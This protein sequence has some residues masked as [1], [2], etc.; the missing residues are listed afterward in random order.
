MTQTRARRR[1]T[2]PPVAEL[3]VPTFIRAHGSGGPTRAAV[4]RTGLLAPAAAFA[5]HPT[6]GEDASD[7]W[8]PAADARVG[9]YHSLPEEDALEKASVV[10]TQLLEDPTDVA[11]W[12]HLGMSKL[13]FNF[14][15]AAAASADGALTVLARGLEVNSSSPSLWAAYLRIFSRRFTLAEARDMMEHALKYVPASPAMWRIIVG[16]HDEPQSAAAFARRAIVALSTAAK[17]APPGPGAA[18][19]RA[20]A[21]AGGAAGARQRYQCAT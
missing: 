21:V 20:A 18:A 5:V 13:D 19:A 14:D 7:E 16:L 8:T 15:N 3:L 4:F 17:A 1:P 12:L 10:E 11:S 6:A 2:R 9:R